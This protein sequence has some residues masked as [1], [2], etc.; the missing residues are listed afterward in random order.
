MTLE[1]EIER[2]EK[3]ASNHEFNL[4]MHRHNVMKLSADDIERTKRYAQENR[5]RAAWLKTLKEIWDS[6][7]CN[8]CRN[9]QCEWK[10]KLGQLVR[11]NCPHYIGVRN[12][13]EMLY[14]HDDIEVSNKSAY[15]AIV[16]AFHNVMNMNKYPLLTADEKAD[17]LN[18]INETL[19]NKG[20]NL[21]VAEYEDDGT[22]FNVHLWKRNPEGSENK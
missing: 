14:K 2:L 20:Y 4:E 3:L 11:F 22:F 1:E 15:R 5:Q 10:P 16:E 18:L 7:D 9:R 8:D 13:E 21:E 19:E 12:G 6:G 17:V